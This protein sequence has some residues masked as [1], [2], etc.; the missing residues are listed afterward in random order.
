MPLLID[1]L[2]TRAG[3]YQR[4]RAIPFGS[5][6]AAGSGRGGDCPYD[7]A[8]KSVDSQLSHTPQQN[9]GSLPAGTRHGKGTR[10]SPPTNV[11]ASRSSG[12][13]RTPVIRSANAKAAAV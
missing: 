9:V 8:G 4:M 7:D 13:T 2:R 1:R 12:V 3:W 11:A 5:E 10:T 6:I